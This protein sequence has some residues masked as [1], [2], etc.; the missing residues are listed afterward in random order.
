MNRILVCYKINGKVFIE[1]KSDLK[2]IRMNE[3]FDKVKILSEKMCS[4]KRQEM[5]FIKTNIK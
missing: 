5:K 1:A 2:E 3:G 4:S